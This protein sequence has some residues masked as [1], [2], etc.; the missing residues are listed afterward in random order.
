V[1]QRRSAVLGT[2]I[3]KLPASLTYE[4]WYIGKDGATPAGTFNA[5]GSKTQSVVLT[6][7]MNAGDSIGVTIEPAGGSTKPTTDP[8]AVVS[9]T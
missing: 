5:D 1:A 4:L 6:G 2:G 7:K 9:T 8:I 3:T